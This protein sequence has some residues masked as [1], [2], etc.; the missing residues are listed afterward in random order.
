MTTLPQS[1]PKTAPDP[2]KLQ[3]FAGHILTEVGAAAAGALVQAGLELGLYEG[4]AEHGPA[5]STELASKLGMNERHLREWLYAQAA[6][7]YITVDTDTREFSMSPEQYAVLVDDSCPAYLGG[8]FNGVRSAY[9]AIDALTQSLRTGTGIAW[10]DQCNCLFCSTAEFFGPTYRGF[11]L[12]DWIPGLD[13]MEARLQAGA[14]VAD[15]GCGF[16]HSTMLLAEQFPNST[17]TGI[18][19]HAPSI[20]AAQKAAAEAGLTNARFECANAENCEGS[21]F[22]LITIF[23]ALHDMGSPAKVAHHV[24]QMLR[25]DGVFMVVEPRAGDDLGETL[26]PVG[27][28]FYSFSTAF[29]TSN[30]LSQLHQNEASIDAQD[31][32]LGAQAG[33]AQISAALQK[34][35]FRDVRKIS[36]TPSLMVLAARP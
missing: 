6:S 16:G 11:L 20:A 12:S 2:E 29:C 36:E 9:H 4:L 28:A 19:L 30:A 26:N 34:G 8:A 25:P 1:L 3:R 27:R 18:D 5:T 35:G 21:A 23:D 24:R 33:P 31:E 14:Q 32:I 10:G 7:A 22:D 13:G 17:F 15:I